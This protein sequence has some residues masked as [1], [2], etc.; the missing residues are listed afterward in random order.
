MYFFTFKILDT[1]EIG[2][3]SQLLVRKANKIG[4]RDLELVRQQSVQQG[5]GYSIWLNGFPGVEKCWWI[6]FGRNFGG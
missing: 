5:I 1:N 2:N 3:R 4:I 6:F